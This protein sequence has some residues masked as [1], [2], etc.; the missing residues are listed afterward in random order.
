MCAFDSKR[1]MLQSGVAELIEEKTRKGR[2]VERAAERKVLAWR[3]SEGDVLSAGREVTEKEGNQPCKSGNRRD[4]VPRKA[5]STPFNASSRLCWSSKLPLTTSI[6]LF[7]S[8]TAAGDVV[9][10]ERA[11][12]EGGVG[13]ARRAL[14]TAPPEDHEKS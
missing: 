7:A 11:R 1:G 12:M 3:S 13:R 8:W 6:P 2:R 9:L 4:E 5:A 10:R 14:T